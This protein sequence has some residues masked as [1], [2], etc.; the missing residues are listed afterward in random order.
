MNGA[1]AIGHLGG[2]GQGPW[3]KSHI[4]CENWLK[5]DHKLKCKIWKYKTFRKQIE[6][7][8]A[9]KEFLNTASKAQSLKRNW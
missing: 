5:M 9:K 4:L 7:F 8:R 1:G 3:P 6:N 2:G